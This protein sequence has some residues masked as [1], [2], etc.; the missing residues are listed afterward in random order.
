MDTKKRKHILLVEDEQHLAVGIEFNL[1][2]EGYDVVRVGDGPSA[3]RYITDHSGQ[4]DLVVLDIMLP[5]M[6]G[7]E[8][9]Q[10]LR[11]SGE[12]LP[13]L[14]LSA[15]TLSEDRTRGFDVGAD[16]YMTKPFELDELLSRVK[17][18]LAKRIIRSADANSH[19][20]GRS[21]SLGKMFTIGKATVNFDTFEVKSI[22]KPT[23]RLTQ[24]QIRLLQYFI[25][26]E[27]R[28]IPRGEL[29]EK[30]WRMPARLQTRRLDQFMRK[31]RIMFEEDPTNPRHFLT[32]RDAGYRFVATTDGDSHD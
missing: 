16:Q 22:D 17:N 12:T 21:R 18:L 27:G 3:L 26:H 15:R 28:V 25:E 8:V 9:C 10:T 1:E 31:L 29:L 13:I 24:M 7:Y 19:Q 4:V 6:S 2:A 5:G 11:A 23:R 20:P 14:V 32:V 30:I